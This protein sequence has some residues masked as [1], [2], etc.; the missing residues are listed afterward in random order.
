MVQADWWTCFCPKGTAPKIL[1]RPSND[2]HHYARDR[3][4]Y[5]RARLGG[6]QFDVFAG[7]GMDG[8]YRRT[9][10]LLRAKGEGLPLNNSVRGT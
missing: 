7:K 5:R 3:P 4:L 6:I 2:L 9:G 8:W 10:W 1:S